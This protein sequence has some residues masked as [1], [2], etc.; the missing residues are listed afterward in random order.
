M[1][2]TSC[3]KSLPGRILR[4]LRHALFPTWVHLLPACSCVGIM[5]SRRSNW[6]WDANY[7]QSTSTR[8]C[9]DGDYSGAVVANRDRSWTYLPDCFKCTKSMIS[10]VITFSGVICVCVLNS[11]SDSHSDDMHMQLL[12]AHSV[13]ACTRSGSPHNVLHSSSSYVWEGLSIAQAHVSTVSSQER[14]V[15]TR[16]FVIAILYWHLPSWWNCERCNNFLSSFR[17]PLCSLR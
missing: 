10:A 3:R 6:S 2:R 5:M 8:P 16:T 15:K 9:K 4:V 13:P 7:E 11:P 1:Y 12:H 14:P 17:H